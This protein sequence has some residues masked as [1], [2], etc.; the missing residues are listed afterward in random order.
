[1]DM[2][3]GAKRDFDVVVVCSPYTILSMSGLLNHPNTNNHPP[4]VHLNHLNKM[5]LSPRTKNSNAE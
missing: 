2:R 4:L 3:N 1:M 5:P